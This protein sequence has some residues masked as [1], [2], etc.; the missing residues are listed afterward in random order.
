LPENGWRGN[1][2]DEH[3]FLV[4]PVAQNRATHCSAAVAARIS[5]A[6]ARLQNTSGY[7]AKHGFST[8]FAPSG[9][10]LALA[11]ITPRVALGPV[12][13]ASVNTFFSGDAPGT[14]GF[15]DIDD[16][17]ANIYFFAGFQGRFDLMGEKSRVA[18]NTVAQAGF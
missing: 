4:C 15:E 1:E 12:L 3:R 11:P 16:T 6:R 5:S 17:R 13:G 9:L 18:P 8:A 14:N 7:R 2:R 10:P